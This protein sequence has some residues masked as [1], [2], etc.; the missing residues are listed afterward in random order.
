MEGAQILNKPLYSYNFCQV[1][2]SGDET[3]TEKQKEEVEVTTFTAPE[4]RILV[5]DDNEINRLIASELLATLLI[6]VDT[7]EDGARAVEKVQETEYDLIL[8][9][10]IMPVMDGVEATQAIRKLEGDYYQNIPIIA[11]T[12]NM[13]KEHQE[14]YLRIGMNDVTAKPIMLEE[15]CEKLRKWMPGKIVVNDGEGV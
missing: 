15:I 12:G 5:V 4:A 3:Q 14:E 1:I 2:T 10:H 8:M 9:D 7:A 6:K 13:G 11:L